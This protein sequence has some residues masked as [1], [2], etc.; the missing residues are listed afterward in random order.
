M[1]VKKG[2][3]ER[4]K[5]RG[6]EDRKKRGRGTSYDDIHVYKM[7]CEFINLLTWIAAGSHAQ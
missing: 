7:G 3:G 4:G 6:R 5:R 1:S 2:E